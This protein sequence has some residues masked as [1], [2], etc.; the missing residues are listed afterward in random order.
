MLFIGH[1]SFDEIDADDNQ[2]HGYFSS[3]VDA[4]TPDDAVAEFAAHIKTMKDSIPA[5]VN[6]VNIYIEEILR[7]ARLPQ[8]PI[9]TRLQFSDGAFPQ[10]V[11]HT[12]PGVFGKEVEAF[13]Y[14]PDIE[15]HEMLN[16]GDYIEAEPFISFE[17]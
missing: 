12:L 6:V 13:G 3:I 5:M 16:D 14:A 17:R 9:I 7:F 10:S 4:Q 15:N 2:R 8:K 11:S 1:F